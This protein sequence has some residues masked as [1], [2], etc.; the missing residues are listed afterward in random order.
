MR[1]SELERTN[2]ETS[3]SEMRDSIVEVKQLHSENERL[4]MSLE[5]EKVNLK[6]IKKALQEQ[7]EQ[8]TDVLIQYE[9]ERTNTE[10]L[11][12]EKRDAIIEA[13]KLRNEKERFVVL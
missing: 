10:T 11:K 2:T 8:N 12:R 3:Q 9:L 13:K 7:M 4:A 1:Q 5:S 6:K